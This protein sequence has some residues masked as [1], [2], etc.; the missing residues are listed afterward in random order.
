MPA[1]ER[2]VAAAAHGRSW[3]LIRVCRYGLPRGQERREHVEVVACSPLRSCIV[4]DIPGVLRTIPL[5][6]CHHGPHERQEIR[7]RRSR[8]RGA[9]FAQPLRPFSDRQEGDIPGGDRQGEELLH[10]L[11]IW[12]QV[13]E[14]VNAQLTEVLGLSF[15]GARSAWGLLTRVAAKVAALNLGIWLHRLFGRPDLVLA[16]LFRA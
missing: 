8:Q 15:P 12:R 11:T 16:T 13:V 7:A 4:Q 10:R 6:P 14:T 2:G 9:Q 1:T 5:F 3:L